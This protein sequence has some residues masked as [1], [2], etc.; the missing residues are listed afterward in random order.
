MGLDFCAAYLVHSVGAGVTDDFTDQDLVGGVLIGAQP[1][2][3]VVVAGDPEGV[4][5][6]G[7]RME[8]AA[9][10][11]AIVIAP[12]FR[13]LE[14]RPPGARTGAVRISPVPP[15]DELVEIAARGAFEP[16]K[17][18]VALAQI[19]RERRGR[20]APGSQG[21]KPY[22]KVSYPYSPPGEWIDSP[23][24]A[25]KPSLSLQKARMTWPPERSGACTL[26]IQAPDSLLR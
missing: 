7:G 25:A 6:V 2:P 4:V 15:I 1:H 19:G 18:N 11:G 10:M 24:R 13:T 17:Q 26:R 14:T 3:A 21:P 16:F 5:A 8:V 12:A 22:T 20:P 23:S 9:D